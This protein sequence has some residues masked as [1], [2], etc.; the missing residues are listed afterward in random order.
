MASLDLASPRVIAI[1]DRGR[2]FSLTVKR[3]DKRAW[4][5]YFEGIVNVSENV[6]GERVNRFDSSAARLDLVES[7]LIGAEGYTT[8]NGQPVTATEGWQK[9]L[10]LAH[11]LTAGLQLVAVAELLDPSADAFT[12]G[13]EDVY[14]DAFWG[15]ERFTGLRHRFRTP[16]GEHQARLSRASSRSVILG[17]SRRGTT[18]WL[19]AQAT[20]ADLYDDLIEEVE[21]YSVNG[22]PLSGREQIVAEM[23]TF[24]KVAAAELLFSPAEVAEPEEPEAK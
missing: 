8:A 12:L 5:R 15:T 6:N 9:L 3:I 1:D 19:G 16:S 2:K 24:H 18:R 13:F 11:R 7:A 14:L 23:D 20:L 10:P 22:T 21:G 4:L 17:G